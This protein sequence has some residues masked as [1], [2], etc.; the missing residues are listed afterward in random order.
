MITV[1]VINNYKGILISRSEL[2]LKGYF[3]FIISSV[4]TSLSLGIYSHIE[5]DNLDYF[6]PE[7]IS[8]AFV[9]LYISYYKPLTATDLN[10]SYMSP[11]K[12]SSVGGAGGGNGSSGESGNTGGSNT[13]DGSGNKPK[14]IPKKTGFK[15]KPAGTLIAASPQNKPSPHF[16]GRSAGTTPQTSDHSIDLNR[17]VKENSDNSLFGNRAYF[18][19]ENKNK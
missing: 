18:D 13:S 6:E 19:K 16:G 7:A 9:G 11:P 10:V 5:I 1:T 15:G 4:V 3:A 14:K 2:Y 8:M 17:P 12:G